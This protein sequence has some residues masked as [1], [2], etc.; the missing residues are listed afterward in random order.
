VK[1][2]LNV[3]TRLIAASVLLLVIITGT[4]GYYAAT[5]MKHDI[6]SSAEQKLISD[7]RTGMELLHSKYPGDWSVG[8]D[9][10]LYKGG[11]LMENNFSIVDRIGQLTGDT[12]T[13]FKGDTRVS[14]NVKKD[15]VRKVGTQAAPEVVQTV[16]KEGRTFLGEADVVGTR[17]LTYY[18]PIKDSQGKIVGM[19]YV[20][21]PATPYDS[22]AAKFAGS[23][24]WYALGGILV[25]GVGAYLLAN[26]VSRP[27]KVI[28]NSIQKAASG[29]LREKTAVERD[30]EI[31]HVGN[32][33]NVM[34]DQM[35]ELIG[36]TQRL[37]QNVAQV[38]NQL[39]ARSDASAKLMENMTTK[40][41]EMTDNARIQ[42]E[43][44]EQTRAIINEMSAGIQQVAYNAQEAST[45][46]VQANA[47]AEEGGIQVEKVVR[48]MEVISDTVNSTAGI[49]QGLGAKSQE[50]GEIV[51]V[52]TG[53]AEQ[54]NLLALNAAI[55]AARAGEQGRGFAV[56]AEEV[57]KLAEESG[58][59][60]KKIAEL[61]KE[62]Q[63]EASRAVQ[64]MADG[65]REVENGIQV[66]AR[67]GEA[68][69]GIIEAIKGITA[70]AQEV[71]AASQQM[72]ASTE[73]AMQA[74]NKTALAANNTSAAAAEI[75]TLAEKQMAGLQEL[76]A[77]IM[78]LTA[79]IGDLESAIEYF[80]V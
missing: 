58:E 26:S 59:A 72:S 56:V 16:L 67:S 52:I 30:D 38:A 31:G 25:A 17:N 71:S 9:G 78:E 75:S 11:V 60:A 62:I 39:Q 13:I 47:T 74:I 5:S 50:I 15:G 73:T 40:S 68:F 70:Q 14:T 45:A 1:L 46:S 19:W 27:L 33:V 32:S 22:M 6:I 51:D 57:R 7:A 48:Q 64:A 20:G 65:T 36:K 53:I 8:P 42:V 35:S 23:M 41:E 43:V 12:V 2:K 69:Q 77:S 44:A 55:E 3:G 34:I 37:A 61:I 21:V 66:V 79:A 10:N 24:L 49:V 54:T 4:M 80:K 76:N 18:E 28:E 63:N 29:D